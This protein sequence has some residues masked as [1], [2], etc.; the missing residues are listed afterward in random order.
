[1]KKLIISTFV[2]FFILNIILITVNYAHAAPI[3]SVMGPPS[4][5]GGSG[6]QSS[7]EAKQQQQVIIRD[8][9]LIIYGQAKS[10]YLTQLSAYNAKWIK[11]GKPDPNN[12][13]V[14]SDRCEP[15]WD[16][17]NFGNP[18]DT[19][20]PCISFKQG[21]GYKKYICSHDK[22]YLNAVKNNHLYINNNSSSDESD[23]PV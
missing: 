1:M 10:F 8:E 9:C 21:G 16:Y 19:N 2:V 12:V 5:G 18:N 23:C 13:I 14:V 17:D 11:N 20:V 22:D 3:G 6:L 15:Y 7:K 4:S